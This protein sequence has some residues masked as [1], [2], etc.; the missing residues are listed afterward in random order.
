MEVQLQT[1]SVCSVYE[2]GEKKKANFH[3]EIVIVRDLASVSR[4]GAGEREKKRG[5][6][7]VLSGSLEKRIMG[8]GCGVRLRLCG[9]DHTIA[10]SIKKQ[11]NSAGQNHL[12]LLRSHYAHCLSPCFSSSFFL[13]S[14]PFYLNHSY[15]D[16]SS[17]P[18]PL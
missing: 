17:R 6:T 11:K 7:P 13:L 14:Q 16:S 9:F 1:A 4:G 2:K 3:T 18:S 15:S 5:P 12:S 10:G 8:L